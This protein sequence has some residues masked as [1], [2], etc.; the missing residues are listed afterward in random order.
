[1]IKELTLVATAIIGP[2]VSLEK[3]QYS[4]R[5]TDGFSIDQVVIQ[6]SHFEPCLWPRPCLAVAENLL[7]DK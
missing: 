1:M 5:G 3:Y 7:H 2:A 6:D 4:K